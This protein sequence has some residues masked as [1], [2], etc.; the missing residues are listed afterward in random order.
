MI[1]TLGNAMDEI[2]CAASSTKNNIFLAAHIVD[3]F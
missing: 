2:D 3:F 1:S